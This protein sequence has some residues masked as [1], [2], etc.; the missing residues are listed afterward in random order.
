MI[1]NNPNMSTKRVL[2]VDDD[3]HICEV[4]SRYLRHM[5]YQPESVQDCY[6]VIEFFDRCTP[7]VVFLDIQLPVI[8]GVKIL[9]LIK[10]M[11]P[12]VFVVMISGVATVETARQAL[13][14]GA[15]DYVT[16][17]FDLQ[18]IADILRAIEL[19]VNIA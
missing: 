10:R 2:I 13:D 9:R 18:R 12:D 17:P 4:L 19:S 11:T 7:D 16:K 8:D 3:P 15:F 6:G 14:Q 5:N 1:D